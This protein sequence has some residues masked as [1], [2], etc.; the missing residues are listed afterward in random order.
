MTDIKA[1]ETKVLKDRLSAI[2]QAW[3]KGH[4]QE[5]HRYFHPD[6]VI[7]A[8]DMKKLGIGR[9]A[10]VKS[11]AHFVSIGKLHSFQ[12]SDY[13]IDIWGNTA[14]AG[15]SFKVDYEIEGKRYAES[16]RDIFV[17]TRVNSEWLAVWRMIQPDAAAE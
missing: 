11:Y 16:G 2:N 10:C 7:V 8:M 12:E 9:D 5:L 1:N 14:T 17:F 4:P 15:Y 3:T 13:I 6:M